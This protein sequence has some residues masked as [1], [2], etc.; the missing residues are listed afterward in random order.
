MDKYRRDIDPSKDKN[1]KG[2]YK[3][4]ESELRQRGKNRN[5]L[6]EIVVEHLE[7]ENTPSIKKITEYLKLQLS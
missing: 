3:K 5:D 6:I 2:L 4:I 7:N 1:G